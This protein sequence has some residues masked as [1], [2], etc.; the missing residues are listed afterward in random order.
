MRKLILQMQCSLDG[1][2]RGPKGELDWVFADLDDEY[3]KWA[4]KKLREAGAHLMGSV[5]YR[6]MA[7]HWPTST[8][9]YAAPMNDIPKV[10]F[11]K[12]LKK[13]EWPET[14]IAT[15]DFAQEILKLKRDEG[16]DLLAHGGVRFAHSLIRAGLVDVYRLVIHPVALGAGAALFP[17][18]PA[19]LRLKPTGE[20][21]FT[22]GVVERELEPA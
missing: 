15:G 13:A 16:R 1:M 2:V 4:A 19:P 17:A 5:T 8:E 9:P 20:K 14:V 18:L 10:V 7:A 22:S 12:K 11:S 6:D 3:G 21:K